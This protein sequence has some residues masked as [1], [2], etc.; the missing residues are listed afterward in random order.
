MMGFLKKLHKWV[1]LLIGLQVLLWLSSGLMI[2]LLD[3]VKV[4][5]KQWAKPD[6]IESQVL[7]PG[8]L[9]EPNA[10][11]AEQLAGA[12]SIS[13]EVI[14]G[15]A[16]YR[17]KRSGSETFVNAVDGVIMLTGKAEA[18][19]LARR[20][21]I[22]V[23]KIVSIEAGQSPDRETR[24]SSGAYWKVKFSDDV[25]TTLYI[26]QSTGEILQ[27][28][29]SFWRVRD[30][31]WML[32]IMDY[33][34]RENFNNS[35][36]IT[37]VLI[38]IWLGISGITLIFGSFSR[39]DFY[40][41]N[42]LRKRDEVVITLIDPANTTPRQVRLRK[43]SNL[44]MSLASHGINLPSVC[45]G[46]GECG[47]CRVKV[48]SADLPAV[49]AIEKLLI[50]RSLREQGFRLACQYR[51]SNNMTLHLTRGSLTKDIF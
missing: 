4:S 38:A 26:A 13:L 3:P 5:G 15:Q 10:L 48:E 16:V 12:L 34:G 29:N 6:A 32:H 39:H 14:L 1:A 23:G 18:E 43:G 30:F 28:R 49:S 51:V 37:V 2:S 19:E 21:F 25:N 46:G 40:F 36:I 41:F 47:K 27:R 33:S 50:P 42:F 45:G 17:I 31:F 7:Q 24:N 35:L 44:F 11:G 22:G 9:L 20:D 8:V